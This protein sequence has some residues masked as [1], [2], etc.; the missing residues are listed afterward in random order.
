MKQRRRN[1]QL[2]F[3]L[4]LALGLR[5]PLLSGSFW[6][7]EAAQALE[8]SRP[9]WQQFDII[10]DFQPPLIHLLTHFA[11]YVSSQEWWLRLI[12][13]LIPGLITI[14][15][16][17]KIGHRFF[18]KRTGNLAS[19]LLATNSFHVF[20]SQELRPYSL[21][22]MWASLSWLC[23]LNLTCKNKN[24]KQVISHKAK[25]WPHWLGYI[26]LTTA[27]LYSSYLYPFLIVS[28]LTYILLTQKKNLQ[29]KF[30]FF[31]FKSMNHTLKSF[32]TSLVV[33]TFLFA[34]WIP[35]FFKQLK[36][37]QAL[38]Q[39]I[40]GWEEV[41]SLTQVKAL[42]LT[43]GKFVFGISNLE[44]NHFYL[45]PTGLLTL[46]LLGLSGYL[47]Y[48]F[49]K[50]KIKIKPIII[51]TTWFVVPL[52]TSWLVSFLVPVVRPKRLLF[53]LPALYLLIAT[54]ID[55]SLNHLNQLKQDKQKSLVKLSA[56]TLLIIL[57][58]LNLFSLSQYYLKPKFQRENWQSL[59]SEI[60]TRFPEKQTIAIF[61]F[62]Q[63]FAPWRWYNQEH[64]PSLAT[65]YNNIEQVPQLTSTLKP[66]FDY[67][68]V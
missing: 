12:S 22:A 15:A 2:F 19:L 32:F 56:I 62:S 42:P 50:D 37:G 28:Q 40:P 34:P 26:L 59:Y 20:Y 25:S 55:L 43:V 27:G 4:L 67:D 30:L 57:F 38:R 13:A 35:T 58:A 17:Y 39:T 49:K 64:F 33:A 46:L 18:S 16:V 6:L 1:R 54:L 31:K 29:K 21:P 48:Q 63:P 66:I 5:I 44:L 7:D 9:L 14:W 65:G 51:T 41:V 24:E 3:I 47:F 61:S 10:P 68:F 11:L 8:S 52:I 36:A 23:L 53:L 60:Q 45:I